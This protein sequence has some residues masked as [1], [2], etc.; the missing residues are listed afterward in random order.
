[1]TISWLIF[2]LK[3]VGARHI[4]AKQCST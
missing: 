1:M 3:K 4:I 2:S